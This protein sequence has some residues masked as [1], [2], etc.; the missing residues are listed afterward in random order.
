MEKRETNSECEKFQPGPPVMFEAQRA[1]ERARA[2]HHFFVNNKIYTIFKQTHIPIEISRIFY[3]FT[4][5][6]LKMAPTFRILIMDFLAVI[7]VICYENMP[8]V[9]VCLRKPL[10]WRD[11]YCTF[12]S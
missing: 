10:T 6:C 3:R 11:R 7:F 8:E 1:V 2:F 12:A 4:R 9:C 5:F